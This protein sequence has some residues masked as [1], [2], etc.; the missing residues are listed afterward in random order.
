[1]NKSRWIRVLL[2]VAATPLVGGC[3]RAVQLERMGDEIAWECP[4]AHMHRELSLS[5]GPMAIGLLRWGAG[6]ADDED[7]QEAKRYLAHVRRIQ[8]AVYKVSAMPRDERV[9]FPR[10]LQETLADD[11]WE[12]LVKATDPGEE[13]LIHYREDKNGVVRDMNIISL[14]DNEG[15]LVLVRLSGDLSQL[16]D[17]ALADAHG[18]T[19]VIDKARK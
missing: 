13:A 12:L 4:Q 5:L 16:F 8:I 19:R 10:Q 14:D 6:L 9:L 3:L 15:E 2:L 11:D 18:V 17:L 7:A 1:M